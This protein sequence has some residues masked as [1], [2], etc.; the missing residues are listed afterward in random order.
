MG[1]SRL[2][3]ETG[4]FEFFE[5]ARRLYLKHGFELCGP[6]ADYKPDPNSVFMTKIL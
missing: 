4:S 5:P 3:L 2:Y 1:L 6:F